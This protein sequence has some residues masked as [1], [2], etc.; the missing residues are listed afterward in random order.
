M[1]ECRLAGYLV[2]T[3][4]IQ[5]HATRLRK[6][7]ASGQCPC[8]KER[9]A[10]LEEHIEAEGGGMSGPQIER[11]GFGLAPTEGIDIDEIE[12]IEWCPNATGT[13]PTQVWM[14][15]RVKGHDVPLVMRFKGPETLDAVIAALT[16]HRIGVFGGHRV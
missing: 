11:K 15:M 9:F 1:G 5:G 10:E 6:R 7:I 2:R 4:S 16:S 8:C 13:N 14:I 12:V 3:S